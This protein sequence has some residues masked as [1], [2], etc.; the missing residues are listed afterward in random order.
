MSGVEGAMEGGDPDVSAT[1][2]ARAWDDSAAV[3]RR[4]TVYTMALQ[5]Q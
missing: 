4:A 3:R 5:L 2:L 1:D